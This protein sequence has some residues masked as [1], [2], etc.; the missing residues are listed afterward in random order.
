MAK[1]NAIIC[2]NEKKLDISDFLL[3]EIKCN[4]EKDFVTIKK[5]PYSI[6]RK[7]EFLAM[8]NI[9][10]VTGK[11]M[12]AYMKKKNI[13]LQ[14]IDQL[15]DSQKAEIMLEINIREDEISSMVKSSIELSKIIIDNGIDPKKHSF[16][17]DNNQTI[18]VNFD[19]L[20]KISNDKLIDFLVNEIKKFSEGYHLGE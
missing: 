5:L 13:P 16:I 19:L 8:N 9:N 4:E 20:D 12:Y 6:K 15:S 7:I 14:N 3:P 2:S 10:S 17:G 1:I 18:E 11:A